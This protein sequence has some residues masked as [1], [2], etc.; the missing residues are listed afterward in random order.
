MESLIPGPCT[1]HV[2][3]E[4]MPDPVDVVTEQLMTGDR[5]LLP[6]DH[7]SGAGCPSSPAYWSALLTALAAR[8]LLDSAVI[9]AAVIGPRLT[10]QTHTLILARHVP[11]I[12]HVAV[13]LTDAPP[14]AKGAD[15]GALPFRSHIDPSVIDELELAGIV[16]VRAATPERSAFGANLVVLTGPVDGGGLPLW[17]G[18][19]R[20]ARGALLVNASG[21]D[22]PPQLAGQVGP[23]FVDDMS[24]LARAA[25]HGLARP[26]Q[27]RR[28]HQPSYRLVG[29]LREV[30]LAE[31]VGRTDPEQ[32]LLVELLSNA[33]PG[34]C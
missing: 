29:D 15:A 10:V 21:R 26:A 18:E 3:G 27:P 11:P 32:V 34:L 25:E 13:C 30:V 2:R 19:V 33:V 20:L 9:T 6:A 23:V 12:S 5:S 28:G 31:H 17:D 8:Y 22:L 24:L 16:V 7:R 4:H 14:P 1:A